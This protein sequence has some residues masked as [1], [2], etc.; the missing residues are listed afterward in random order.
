M[1]L[2]FTFCHI[3]VK[4]KYGTRDNEIFVDT[5]REE[6]DENPLHMRHPIKNTFYNAPPLAKKVK[7]HMDKRSTDMRGHTM[8]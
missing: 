4:S 6:L 1:R 7:E 8:L 2:V 5:E 3:I